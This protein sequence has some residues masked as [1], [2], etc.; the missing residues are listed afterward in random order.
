MTATSV[1]RF[2]EDTKLPPRRDI[3]STP[4]SQLNIS[5][6]YY[7]D[8]MDISVGDRRL[9]FP[10]GKF[11]LKSNGS[12]RCVIDSG[13]MVLQEDAYDPILHEFDEH[14]ASFGV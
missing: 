10:P 3:K 7:V 6:N 4:L 2:G 9:G 13:A 5:W 11:D 1:L 12:G 8:L 14:F